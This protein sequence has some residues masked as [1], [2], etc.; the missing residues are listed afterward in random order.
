MTIQRMNEAHISQIAALEAACFSAPW[1]EDCLRYELTNGLALW[2][3]ALEGENVVGYVGSQTVM[4]ES[5]MMNIA[6]HPSH[7][8]RG[9]AQSLLDE[10]ISR[11]MQIS[12]TCLLLEVRA[13]NDSAIKLYEKNG[14]LQVGLRKNY[15]K[16]PKED[17]LILKKEFDIEEN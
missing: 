11:L 7:R 5:D 15:Y 8:R 6:V 3:V 13:S 2:L 17:A 14:F 9:I 12:S 16:N 1:S 4:G 10:L